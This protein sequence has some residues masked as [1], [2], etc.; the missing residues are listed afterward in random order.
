[1]AKTSAPQ[2]P[3][4][5]KSPGP[6]GNKHHDSGEST[7]RKPMGE[8]EAGAGGGGGMPQNEL[9]IPHRGETAHSSLLPANI[10]HGGGE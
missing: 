4:S 9:G 7:F 8:H 1:M 5:P 3:E 6:G 10:D 2:A